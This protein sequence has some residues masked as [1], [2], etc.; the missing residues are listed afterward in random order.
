MPGSRRLT[1]NKNVVDPSDRRIRV[2]I[3]SR[4]ALNTTGVAGRK[5]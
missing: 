3:V 1:W 2:A 4:F 5:R